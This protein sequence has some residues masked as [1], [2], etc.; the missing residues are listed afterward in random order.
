MLFSAGLTQG[1]HAVYY[2][3]SFLRWQEIG[4]S[5]FT[6]GCLWATG[7]IAEIFLLSSAR[8]MVRRPARSPVFS[9]SA[10]R[11]R[12]PLLVRRIALEPPLPVLFLL[13]LSHAGTFA[14][15][16]LGAIEFMDRAAPAPRQHRH[17]DHVDDR[18][19]QP[20]CRF[21]RPSSPAMSGRLTA[22][23]HHIS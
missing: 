18:R 9:C 20:S 6:I 19:Q 14:C 4:Y 23:R 13:Q 22:P 17:D 12:R 21:W 15:A 1:A 3:F 5:S 7:V 16:Y 11:R 8:R 10:A 2:A